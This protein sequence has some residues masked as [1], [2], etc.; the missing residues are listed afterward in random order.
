MSLLP[1]LSRLSPETETYPFLTEAQ[2]ARMRPYSEL[3]SVAR[4]GVLYYPGDLAVPLFVLLSACVEVV[5]PDSEADSPATLLC[6]RRFRGG[7]GYIGGQRAFLLA[8]VLGGCV[9]M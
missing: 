5:Q 1:T 2:I 4:G 8:R 7:S 6:T 3:R 9:G